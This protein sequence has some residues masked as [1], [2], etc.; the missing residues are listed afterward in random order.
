MHPPTGK[1]EA[2]KED[3]IKEDSREEWLKG[4]ETQ[5]MPVSTVGKWDTTPGTVH[6]DEDKTP[7]RI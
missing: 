2:A 4:L 1:D 7:N 6:R 3:G 5:T